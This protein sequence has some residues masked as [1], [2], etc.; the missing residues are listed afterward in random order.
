MILFFSSFLYT[1]TNLLAISLVK[2]QK[3]TQWL[4]IKTY[5]YIIY[6]GYISQ[7]KTKVKFYNTLKQVIKIINLKRSN[8]NIVKISY[9]KTLK[10]RKSNRLFL[11]IHLLSK[12]AMIKIKLRLPCLL[13][14]YTLVNISLK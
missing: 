10:K 6:K 8:Y 13:G 12:L 14:L 1:K 11:A 7:F 4:L 3:R 5:I 9:H 2:A